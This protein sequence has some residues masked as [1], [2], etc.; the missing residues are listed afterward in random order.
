MAA[1]K[2]LAPFRQG[3]RKRRQYLTTF[4]YTGAAAQQ[5]PTPFTLPSTGMLS[6]LILVA[7]GAI[8]QSGGG[9]TLGVDGLAGLFNQIV[10]SA[11]LGSANLFQASGAG[12]DIAARWHGA[13]APVS[14]T[15]ALA[16]QSASPF[17]YALPIDIAMNRKKQFSLGLINLQDPEIQVQLAV[18]F[19]PLASVASLATSGGGSTISVDVYMEYFEVPD[20]R[21]FALPIR[22]I[23]RT[24]EDQFP[25]STQVGNNI[26][27]V[28]RLGIMTDYSSIIYANSARI[29]NANM[30]EMDVRFNKTD[31]IETRSGLLQPVLDSTDYG[32]SPG[33]VPGTAPTPGLANNIQPGVFTWAGWNATDVVDNGDF[34]DAIDTLELTTTEIINVVAAGTTVVA[35]DIIRAVRRTFQVLG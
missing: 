32:A 15:F 25:Q 28:P 6:R 31:Y 13:S 10:V 4:V 20:P 26:Y 3:T 12:A 11:N 8:D 7:H 14:G 23:A 34:R 27:T 18:T 17:Y 24:L 21:A 30:Q 16:T 5:R 1:A 19:N 33:V 29:S 9:G 22:A 35:G 2:Q